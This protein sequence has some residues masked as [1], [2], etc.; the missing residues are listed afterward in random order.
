MILLLAKDDAHKEQHI[1]AS[2][3]EAGTTYNKSGKSPYANLEIGPDLI[4]TQS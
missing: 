4:K 2:L 3:N 1:K